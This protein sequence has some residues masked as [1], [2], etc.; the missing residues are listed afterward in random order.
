MRYASA[1]RDEEEFVNPN[2]FDISRNRT[3]K[4]GSSKCRF[5]YPCPCKKSRKFN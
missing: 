3:F 2:T 5:R 4:I 1:N